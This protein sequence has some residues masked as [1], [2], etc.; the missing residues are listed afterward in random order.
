MTP[1]NQKALDAKMFKN[2]IDALNY[3]LKEATTVLDR[4]KY[5]N[6][7]EDAC[8]IGTA[9]EQSIVSDEIEGV[10]RDLCFIHCGEEC[11]CQEPIAALTAQP[12][13][14]DEV[15]EVLY[16][17]VPQL[18]HAK[19]MIEKY[20]QAQRSVI[21]TVFDIDILIRAATAP[22]NCDDFGVGFDLGVDCGIQYQMMMY[23]GRKPISVTE[24]KTKALAAHRAQEGKS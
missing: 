3:A 12:V 15:R 11:D 7:I 22:K 24:T 14:D 19:E 13:T 5:A 8:Y 23:Q 20:P 6:A 9:L 18:N 10:H 16:V 1:A 21:V 17:C 2:I 4:E